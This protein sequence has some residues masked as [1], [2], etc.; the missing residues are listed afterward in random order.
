MRPRSILD[1]HFEQITCRNWGMMLVPE[2]EAGAQYSL[3]PVVCL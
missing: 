1:L 2:N 3:S